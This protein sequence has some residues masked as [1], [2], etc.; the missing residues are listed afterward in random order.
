MAYY[1]LSDDEVAA[2]QLTQAADE[3]A[4][5]VG[6]G[7]FVYSLAN[8]SWTK[9]GTRQ[10]QNLLVQMKVSNDFRVFK[11]STS[12]MVYGVEAGEC[13]YRGDVVTYAGTTNETGLVNSDTNYIYLDLTSGSAV[14]VDNVTGFPADSATTPHIRLATIA[15]GVGTFD[16]GDI[17]D[18]R[19]PSSWKVLGDGGTGLAFFSVEENTDGVG[20]PNVLTAAE[21]GKVLTNEGAGAK[22]YHTLPA[23]VAGLNYTFIIKDSDGMR[24]VAGA[25]DTIRIANTVS[26]AAG[27]IDSTTIGSVVTLVAINA[28][29]W[30]ASTDEGTWA[31]ETS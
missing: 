13:E 8:E 20:D 31:V 22:N 5:G 24:I 30:M 11:D 2:L 1:V 21:S 25:G 10:E 19:S 15:T 4:V 6:N 23:A 28:T 9:K 27:Y 14:L 7:G 26:V 29:E 17:V 16:Y 18:C 12:D 3:D